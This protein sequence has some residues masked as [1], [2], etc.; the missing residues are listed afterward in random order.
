MAMRRAK[1]KT[2]W[3]KDK[4]D[5]VKVL[6]HR[7]HALVYAHKKYHERKK[8]QLRLKLIS[9][10]QNYRIKKL[11]EDLYADIQNTR[12]REGPLQRIPPMENKGEIRSGAS[13]WREALWSPLKK[14]LSKSS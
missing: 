1:S 9:A 5:P 11:K 3:Q 2:Q 8:Q 7:N 12:G 4:L 6:R 14:R 13:R 10:L